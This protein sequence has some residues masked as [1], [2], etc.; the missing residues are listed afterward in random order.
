MEDY[1][2]DNFKTENTI[3][4]DYLCKLPQPTTELAYLC[5]CM[6]WPNPTVERATSKINESIF[7]CKVRIK[8][9]LKDKKCL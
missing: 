2:D 4:R 5:Q 8:I 6:K 9:E 1:N 7:S 3:I